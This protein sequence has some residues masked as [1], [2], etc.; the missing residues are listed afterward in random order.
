[1]PN[2]RAN[3][4][5]PILQPLPS[6]GLINWNAGAPLTLE[7]LPAG[8]EPGLYQFI[9]TFTLITPASSGTLTTTT[10]WD[11]PR[12]GAT[13]LVLALG[14]L[15]SGSLPGALRV[16][17]SSGVSAIS[18]LLTPAAIVGS[19]VIAVACAARLVAFP[20]EV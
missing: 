2:V 13:T 15:T 8:H 12:F 10:S 18:M 9:Q 14:N 6:E 1:M 7:V 4:F 3:P 5:N 19:P 17:D 11:Q 20:V 16:I